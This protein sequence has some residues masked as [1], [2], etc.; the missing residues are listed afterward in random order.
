MK[1]I[2]HFLKNKL[3]NKATIISI[4]FWIGVAC[5][6][7]VNAFHEQYTDEWDNILGGWYI[8]HG[9]LPYIG[10]FSHHGPV[11]YFLA[12]MLEIFSRRSF[13]S[14]RIVYEIFLFLFS[15]GTLLYLRKSIGKLHTAFLFLL[16]VVIGFIST[17][18]WFHML[19]ADSLAAFF[20]LPIFALL[21]LNSF[22]ERQIKGNDVKIISVCI[23]F[24]L[25][26]SLTYLYLAAFLYLFTFVLLV[27]QTP[28]PFKSRFIYSSLITFFVPYVL[29]LGYL[30]A[31]GSVKDYYYQSIYFNQKYYIYNYPGLG[32]INPIRY[33]IIIA[34]DALNGLLTLL[35]QVKD[36]NFSYP[37]NITFALGNVIFLIYLL[38]KR[39]FFLAT[40]TVLIVLYANARS[41]PLNS[42]EHDYQSAV[43][44]IYSLFVLCFLLQRL[45]G[46]LIEKE[47]N[48]RIILGACFIPLAVYSIFSGVF[49]LNKF[50]NRYFDKFMG[51]APLIY[52]RPE[53]APIINA[54]VKPQ[55]Y[56]WVGPF[57]Y[58]ELFYINGAPASKYHV[59]NPGMGIS[60]KISTEQVA[61]LEKTQPKVIWYNPRY[62][63]L[64]RSP[65]DYATAFNDY[66]SKNYITVYEYREG[67]N[68]YIPTIP[69]TFHVD[70]EKYLNMRKGSEKEIIQRLLLA[71]YIKKVSTK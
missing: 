14:F 23:F 26:T 59:L 50:N 29:F 65:I 70:I 16:V 43:Y 24:A 5:L 13:V 19:L 67:N 18:Y 32:S 41:N 40:L 58:E 15:L 66:L 57:E 44:I 31:T 3:K 39:R 12:A 33:A 68:K 45:Y 27:R 11:P 28:K 8:L 10:F 62:S 36:F 37:L 4:L 21:I 51:T 30:L 42:G 1:Q 34:H 46:E 48:Q 60:P 61:D 55:E 54:I 47:N 35:V 25:L 22:F 53:I 49:V 20:L 64:G 17:Y 69:V 9:R 63:I 71:G 7:Y 56:V 52:D 6:F 38:S 2:V